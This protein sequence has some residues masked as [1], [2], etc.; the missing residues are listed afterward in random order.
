MNKSNHIFIPD[1]YEG[2]CYNPL[3][4]LWKDYS[5]DSYP[6]ETLIG[7]DVYYRPDSKFETIKVEVTDEQQ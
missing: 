1:P 3:L 6:E 7:N 5:Q 2:D 4:M